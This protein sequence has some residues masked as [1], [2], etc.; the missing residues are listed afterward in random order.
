MCLLGQISSDKF[1]C[2]FI[3][4]Y[5]GAHDR[6]EILSDSKP[7]V[8]LE[9]IFFILF[10]GFAS[11]PSSKHTKNAKRALQNLELGPIRREL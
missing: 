6:K 4:L 9:T 8:H 7:V 10:H 1:A 2:I 11:C 5:Q 3:S